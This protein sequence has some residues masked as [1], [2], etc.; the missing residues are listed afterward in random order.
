MACVESCR[1]YFLKGEAPLL[2]VVTPDKILIADAHALVFPPV[3]NGES[4][5]QSGDRGGKFIL[6]VHW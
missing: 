3:L 4:A 5:V 1:V 6:P 2:F